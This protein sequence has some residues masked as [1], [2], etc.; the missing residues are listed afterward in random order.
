MSDWLARINGPGVVWFNGFLNKAEVDL[1]RWASSVGGNDPGATAADAS[2]MAWSSSGGPGSTF[3]YLSITRPAGTAET[4]TVWWRPFSAFTGATNGK[5]TNDPGAGGT[6]TPQAWI[7]QGNVNEFVQWNKGWYTQ[8]SSLAQDGTDFYV[9]IRVKMDPN[10]SAPGMNDPCKLIELGITQRTFTSQNLVTYLNGS[11]G[12]PA[13]NFHRMYMNYNVTPIEQDDTLGRP[14]Q[15]VGGDLSNYGTGQYCNI[16][17]NTGRCWAYSS[18]WDTLLYHIIPGNVAGTTP[19][20]IQVWAAHEGATSYT[21]IWDLQVLSG[22][23]APGQEGWNQIY[24]ATY[25]N[26]FNQPLGFTS[27]YAQ[28]IFSK[29][30]IP[31][32]QV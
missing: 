14:G 9:Q 6:V 13:L 29:Q 20:T 30:F 26:G 16:S 21:K 2:K 24:L 22:W 25:C 18:G 3:P 12:N 7:P 32:P 27:R 31:C 19:S 15:Q 8:N 23:Q 4:D 28:I 1:Y 11:Y 17:T 5:G 10:A